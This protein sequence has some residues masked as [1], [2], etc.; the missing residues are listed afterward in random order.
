M[1]R[2]SLLA[3]TLS[4]TACVHRVETPVV[5]TAKSVRLLSA[6]PERET[7]QLHEQRQDLE[8]D[9]DAERTPHV[10]ATGET[11]LLVSEGAEVTL[12]GDEAGTK[13]FEVDNFLLIE[14]VLPDGTIGN[15][16]V[17]GYVNGVSLGKERID[18]LGRRAFAH[19][20]KEISLSSAVP[21]HGSFRLRA[22]ALDTGGVG[23]VSD[24]FVIVTPRKSEGSDDLR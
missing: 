3:L 1:A 13:G 8:V 6:A 5:V 10:V 4:L 19:D 24:V 15:R 7:T 17:V 23:R 22:T 2:L 18:L 16:V 21:E 11:G 12:A 20:A 14:V 9:T